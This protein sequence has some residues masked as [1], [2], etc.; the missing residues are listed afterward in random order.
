VDGE[1]AVA[2]SILLGLLIVD[3]SV[4][5]NDERGGQTTEINDEMLDD[6]LPPKMEPMKSVRPQML[7]KHRFRGRHLL[8]QFP[9]PRTE[10]L[11]ECDIPHHVR[12]QESFLDSLCPD[13]S[14]IHCF[15]ASH[16]DSR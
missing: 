14:I 16:T 10:R 5:L 13:S 4:N 8:P 7:P 11:M 15:T 2:F 9:C 1:D 12:L 6:L 3:R